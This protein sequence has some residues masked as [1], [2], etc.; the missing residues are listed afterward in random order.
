M[1]LQV[2]SALDG[3]SLETVS[4]A[5]P[6][7]SPHK[8]LN[9]RDDVAG[10]WIQYGNSRNACIFSCGIGLVADS[11]HRA[12]LCPAHTSVSIKSP[13]TCAAFVQND[14]RKSVPF[15]GSCDSAL[16]HEWSDFCV[17]QAGLA[18]Q[19]YF[20]VSSFRRSLFLYQFHNY[21]Q[22]QAKSDKMFRYW[23]SPSVSPRS[24]HLLGLFSLEHV[25]WVF[26]GVSGDFSVNS[27]C[28]SCYL[29]FGSL[30]LIS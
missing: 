15:L 10:V 9:R 17:L 20:S 22:S 27:F 23:R 6:A 26:S 30:G 5:S 12:S 18:D 28:N 24:G 21:L 25:P 4:T 16:L 11:A 1:S 7:L 19:N 8:W 29:N 3:T 14:P 2:P 13:R